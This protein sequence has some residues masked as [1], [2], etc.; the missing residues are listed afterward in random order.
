MKDMS[1]CDLQQ[2]ADPPH[3]A[4]FPLMVLDI[5]FPFSAY[6]VYAVLVPH[7][8]TSPSCGAITTMPRAYALTK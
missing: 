6:W 2:A 1:L 5:A 3:W 8:Y 7:P 4:N